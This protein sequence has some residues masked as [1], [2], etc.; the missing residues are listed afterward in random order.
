MSISYFF[1]P[2]LFIFCLLG[3][4]RVARIFRKAV[5]YDGILFEKIFIRA[6]LTPKGV[7]GSPF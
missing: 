7:D 5:L 4:I 2:F 1:M 6:D 3:C